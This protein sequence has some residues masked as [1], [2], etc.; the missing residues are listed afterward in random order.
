MK[1]RKLYISG[2][3]SLGLALILPLSLGSCSRDSVGYNDP[4]EVIVNFSLDL[5]PATRGLDSSGENTVKTIDILVFKNNQLQYTA[6]GTD[7]TNWDTSNPSK[8]FKVRLIEDS[9]IELMVLV[10][11][12]SVVASSSGISI[13]A[14]KSSIETNLLHT[15]VG[16]YDVNDPDYGHLPMWGSVSGVTITSSTSTLPNIPVIRMH[17]KVDVDASAVTANF[18]LRSV[19]VYNYETKG[20]FVPDVSSTHWDAATNKAL[21]PSVPLSSDRWGNP[22]FSGTGG[23]ILHYTAI[24]TSINSCVGEIYLHESNNFNSSGVLLSSNDRT[25]LVIGGLYDDDTNESYYRVDFI[26]SGSS[27]FV[28][29]LRNHTYSIAIDTVSNP[30]HTDPDDAFKS[31]PV[32]LEVTIIDWSNEDLNHELQ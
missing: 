29:L 8:D 3:L 15:C 14:T 1:I 30:G 19:R 9:S 32:G 7:I 6:I 17:A 18:E 28:N 20:R 5:P 31:D 21:L 12:R 27:Q 10:N 11:A 24:N 25:C 4:S 2:L 22:S 26:D 23:V 16:I 13:N